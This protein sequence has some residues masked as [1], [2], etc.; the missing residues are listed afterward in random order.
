M[1]LIEACINAIIEG[2]KRPLRSQELE[3]KLSHFVVFLTR[4]PKDDLE[5]VFKQGLI[6]SLKRG[7]VLIRWNARR[8]DWQFKLR[9]PTN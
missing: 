5:K 9:G 8:K 2:E 7:R 1:D 4:Q 3:E 6:K